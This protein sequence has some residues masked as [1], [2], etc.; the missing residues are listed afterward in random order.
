[1]INSKNIFSVEEKI[2]LITGSSRGIG[3]TLAKAFGAAG[4]KVILN[5]R[6]N[7][8]LCQ[9]AKSLETLGYQVYTS[10]F[11]VFD[12]NKVQREINRIEKNVGPIDVLINNAGIQRRAQL[13]A[14]SLK[15]WE[16]VLK[17]NLTGAF[18]T[19]REAV[20]RMLNRESGK[21]INICSLM[22]ELGRQTT[23]AYAASKGGLKML[24]KAMTV[25]WAK[26]NIQ[27]NGIGPGYFITEM[28]QKLADDEN[29]DSW[30]KS[31]TPAG[32]W[33]D[34]DEL[35]G[36]AIFL[37]SDASSFINGQVIY[38]DGGLLAGI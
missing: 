5:G 9:A 22:S 28:T 18:I 25:E 33:G 27:I 13:E 24:T 36:T 12:E 2:V 4:A 3:F 16:E 8:T 23:G 21:I 11:D 7:T 15:D 30:L 29:F 19:S 20:K 26:Y 32:R 14:L 10:V 17:V 37:S 1:M 31:R 34:P 35:T 38:V 6:N